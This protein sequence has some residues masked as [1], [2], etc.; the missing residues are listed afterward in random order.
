MRKHV[1]P[2]AA[3]VGRHLHV[4]GAGKPST[5]SQATGSRSRGEMVTGGAAIW[6][7]D[8]QSESKSGS[9]R[10]LRG[11]SDDDGRI[12]VIAVRHRA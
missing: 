9:E 5:E 10:G 11:P 7:S 12:F 3:D 1:R 4:H 6:G 8:E 2:F